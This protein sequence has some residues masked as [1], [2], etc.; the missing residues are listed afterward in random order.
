MSE[1]SKETHVFSECHRGGIIHVANIKGGVGK[2]TVATNLAAS[3]SKYGST[4]IID[5]DV[6]GSASAAL[7]KETAEPG[8]SS[9]ALFQ[10]R[11]RADN[12]AGSVPSLSSQ[13]GGIYLLIEKYVKYLAARFTGRRK[14]LSYIVKKVDCN[15]DLVAANAELFK[16]PSIIQMYTLLSNIRLARRQYKY[17]ILDT[18][19]VWNRITKFLYRHVDLN[20]IPVTLNAL[21]TKSLRDYLTNVRTL[22]QH[23]PTVRIRIVKNE[24]YGKQD[25]KIKGKI[26]TMNENRRFLDSLCEQALY[27]GKNGYSS[28]P[29]SIIFDLEIPESAIILDA[30]DEGKLLTDYHQYSA[31]ARAFEELGKRVQYVLNIPVYSDAAGIMARFSIMSWVPRFAALVVLVG[32]FGFTKPVIESTAPS[33]VAPQKLTVPLGGFFNHTFNKGESMNRA[34]KH[35]ITWFRATVPSHAQVWDYIQEVVTI[36]NITREK[37][38][39]AI[40]NPD[41]IPAG[42]SI[43]FFPPSKIT[44]PTENE[45]LPVYRYFLT[46]VEEKFA[47]ITG[48]WCERGTGGGQPHYGMDVAAAQGTNIVSPVFGV[49]SLKTDGIAG[50]TV[51]IE[52]ENA[53]I[54]FCH[55]DRR[56]VKTGDTVQQGD[57]I[58]TVG[59][60]GRSTGPHVHVGYAVRSQ[61]RTDIS[62]GQKRYM[63]TDPKLFYFR[64]VF[65]DKLAEG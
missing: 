34:A 44:N 2:T 42:T 26:R 31:A 24:V 25:S 53:I 9:W 63:V 3:L 16:N 62:F 36:Y 27:K 47:Y 18:P 21:S 4:L 56:F 19:S 17:V 35:A 20:L 39:P 40:T 6:Q 11:Y 23:H 65:M 38:R 55:M 14:P 12:P 46:I 29:Q 5:L 10:R 7:G 58:G 22:V 32:V 30:Q 60:T 59:N 48:D 54:F 61:S 8:F 28:L 15:L 37:G 41:N 13:K 1:R 33:P 43:T 51:G 45:L 50:R 64:K 52:H 57:V 49:V